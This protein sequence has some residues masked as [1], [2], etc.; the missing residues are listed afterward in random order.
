MLTNLDGNMF[1]GLYFTVAPRF[2]SGI[3]SLLILTG[4]RQAM[5]YK[6]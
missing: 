4:A 3:K 2:K 1:K 6:E 5:K